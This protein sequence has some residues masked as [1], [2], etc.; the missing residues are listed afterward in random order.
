MSY[1]LTVS[2]LPVLRSAG[3]EAGRSGT[4][5]FRKDKAGGEWQVF[6][7]DDEDVRSLMFCKAR[8]TGR[9]MKRDEFEELF[10]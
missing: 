7:P 6:L 8:T 1:I 9:P 3:F 10:G 5:W 4:T 2:D